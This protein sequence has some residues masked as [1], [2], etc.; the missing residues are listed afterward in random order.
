LVYLIN[1]RYFIGSSLSVSAWIG[2]RYAVLAMSVLGGVQLVFTYA[3]FMQTAF[4]SR[5]L[6][7]DAWL[8]ILGA[9]ALLFLLVEAEKAVARWQAGARGQVPAGPSP[10]AFPVRVTTVLA[11]ALGLVIGAQLL[12]VVAELYSLLQATPSA[13]VG[14]ALAVLATALAAA[15]LAEALFD[16][17]FVGARA[18]AL[19]MLA[20]ALLLAVATHAPHYPYTAAELPWLLSAAIAL[21]ALGVALLGLAI[22]WRRGR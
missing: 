8:R 14:A 7:A 4:A 12:A 20:P 11:G 19:K 2:N 18:A 16:L 17:R 10:K 15:L 6:N 5:A 3:P 22:A 9:A 21:L 13:S 1:S